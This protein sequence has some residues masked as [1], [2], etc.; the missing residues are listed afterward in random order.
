MIFQATSISGWWLQ[1]TPFQ[2]IM[3]WVRQL[4]WFSI[5]NC[6]W[7][8]QIQWWYSQLFLEKY[9]VHV[10]K[11]TKQRKTWGFPAIHVLTL[12]GWCKH[13]PSDSHETIQT[14]PITSTWYHHCFPGPILMAWKV[15]PYKV[16]TPLKKIAKLV[17]NS[18]N[19]SLWYL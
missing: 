7:K 18:N 19:Y 17:F 13:I 12:T 5:P 10:Q 4:G 9:T 8:N 6:F 2:E 11:T 14:D 3:E 15:N 16:G 1:P